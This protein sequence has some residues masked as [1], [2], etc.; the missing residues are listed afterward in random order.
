MEKEKQRRFLR[1]LLAVFLPIALGALVLFLMKL[2]GRGIPCP[3]RTLTGFSCPGCGNTRAAIALSH[4]RFRESLSYNYAYPLEFMYL[5][6][7]YGV[8]AYHFV[9]RGKW[10]FYPKHIAVEV[11]I[12]VLILAW[13]I[14]R[15]VLGA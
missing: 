7:V 4:L 6:R 1:L 12:L 2:F 3:I 9:K 8:A 15:N 5:A 10:F 14:V 13:G 11:V